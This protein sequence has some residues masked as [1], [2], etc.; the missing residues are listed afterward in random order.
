MATVSVHTH[1]QVALRISGCYLVAGL[2]WILLTDLYLLAFGYQNAAGFQAAVAKGS[3]FVLVSAGLVYWLVSRDYAVIL[4]A[5][6]E[7][8]RI[9]EELRTREAQLKNMADA[10]PQIVWIADAQGNLVHLNQKACDYSGLAANNLSG[11]QWENIVHPD[12]L[13]RMHEQWVEVLQ[14][15]VPV[16]LEFRLQR[17]DGQYRWHIGR[18]VPAR[19]SLQQIEAWYGT[20]TDIEDRKQAERVLRESEQRYRQLVE[21]LPSAI[22]IHIDQKIVVCNPAFLSLV[23]AESVVDVHG[24][25][26]REIISEADYQKFELSLESNSELRRAASGIEMRIHRLDGRTVPVSAVAHRIA[27]PENSGTLVVLH[28]LTE[29]ER[30]LH[31]LHSV[32]A[33]VQDAII[34]INDR[35]EVQSANPAVEKLFGYSP[36]ELTGRSLGVLMPEPYLT[37]HTEYMSRQSWEGR[38]RFIGTERELPGR[39]KDGSEFP[40]LLTVTEFELEGRSHYTGVVRDITE[41][42]RLESRIHEAQKMEAVGRLAGGVAH[43]FNNL[44]TVISGYSD[45]LLA[46]MPERD[47]NR[48]SVAAIRE[49][50]E[51]A[52]RLTQQLLAF[53]RRAI[54]EP[55]ILNLSGLVADSASLLRRII[56]EDILLF[57]ETADTEA[58]IKADPGQIEQVIMNL[59][60]NARDAMPTGGRLT[61]STKLVFVAEPKMPVEDGLAQ[62]AYM[63]LSVSD[64]GHGIPAE[65]LPQIFD[66]FFTTKAVGKGTGLGLA[67]AHGVIKQCG[68]HIFVDSVVGSGTTFRVLF[69]VTREIVEEPSAGLRATSES[70]METVLLV[71]DEDAVRQIARI[72]LET[73]GFT[74]LVASS[75]EAAIQISQQYLGPIDLLVTDVV[76]PEIS[77]RQLVDAIRLQ[78]PGL[79]ALYMSG[80]MDDSIVQH[81]VVTSRDAFI[82]KPFTPLTLAR[83]VRSVLESR[84]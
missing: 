12:D 65:V 15:G 70:G 9:S 44:L 46:T 27:G 4:K 42:K 33:S 21:V 20:C 45:L 53:S 81:G 29:A 39:R 16:D 73:R 54:I 49:A 77:G 40:M 80:Y 19:N 61:V 74:V 10:I 68:G 36:Q 28:D 60:V 14:T 1:R 32:L 22:Y 83:K 58:R 35:S 37:M 34:T 51:R 30:N 71:E 69:P 31:L 38:R 8:S 6:S 11:W 41:K 67:V 25:N 59:I 62:G 3:V 55:R 50:G 64:S 56:G 84:S 72:A 47:P 52:A 82:R 78:R 2:L 76:M 79:R 48:E 43:D 7:Q 18:Q 24:R 57:V 17:N 66:P 5:I 75:G 23:G 13:T 26:S 63:E